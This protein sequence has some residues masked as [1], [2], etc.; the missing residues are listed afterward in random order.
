MSAI[1]RLAFCLAVVGLAG[2][3]WAEGDAPAPT[4]PAATSQPAP[5]DPAAN[6]AAAD[7]YKQLTEQL[8]QTANAAD[9]VPLLEKFVADHPGTS[10][11]EQAKAELAK[12]KDLA[13]KGMARFGPGWIP[14]DDLDKKN[15]K[16]SELIT[17]ADS[18]AD[19]K[20]GGV[21]KAAKTLTEAATVNP[22]RADIPFK[23]F[24]MLLKNNM[25]AEA[26]APLGA[27]KK[28]QPNSAPVINDMGVLSARQKQWQSAFD[29]L[30]LAASK[31]PDINAIWDNFDQA[32]AMAKES[33]VPDA[34]LNEVDGKLRQM[35]ARIHKAGTHASETRWGN[36]WISEKDYAAYTKENQA[37]VNAGARMNAES[38]RLNNEILFCQNKQKVIQGHSTKY[39]TDDADMKALDGRINADKADLDKLKRDSEKATLPHDPS[40]A[41]KLVLLGLDNNELQTLDG[42]TLEAE[43]AGTKTPAGGGTKPKGPNSLFN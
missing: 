3:I 21:A 34:T 41:G 26:G 38:T 29:L 12:W 18:E 32:V 2:P 10:S 20:N 27:I 11:A 16:V 43:T 6:K 28:I 14:K 24:E 9:G 15:A 5:A 37:A 8:N 35:I 17:R 40:H 23:K 39:A 42:K 13:A 30:L 1:G 22:Y 33:G 31:A 7:E 36:S 19:E 25:E 4:A